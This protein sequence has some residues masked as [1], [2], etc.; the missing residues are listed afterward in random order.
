MGNLDKFIN[1]MKVNNAD[2]Y[3][4]DY[5]ENYPQNDDFEEPARIA[6]HSKDEEPYEEDYE[7]P[8]PQKKPR[9]SFMNAQAKKNQNISRGVNSNMEVC[10]CKPQV[11]EDASQIADALLSERSVVLNLEGLDSH[12]AIRIFDFA[13]GACYAL[14]GRL[15]AISKFVYVITPESV[16]ISGDTQKE[17][18]ALGNGFADK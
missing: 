5:E 10:L 12:L 13:T 2:D 7:A 6:N 16:Y 18:G 15:E 9:T 3:E 1:F 4:E 8:K 17:A 14:K 11:F